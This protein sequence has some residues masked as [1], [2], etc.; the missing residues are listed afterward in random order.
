M[1][2]RNVEGGVI[3]GGLFF[4]SGHCTEAEN[5]EKEIR[6]TLEALGAA[7]KKQGASFSDVVK[8]TVFLRDLNDRERCLNKIW[9]EYFPQNPPARTCVEAGIGRCRVEIEFVV[10]LTEQAGTRHS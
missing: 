9:K 10:A 3:V 4:T 8:A 6:G 5:L 1:S 2:R 7:I